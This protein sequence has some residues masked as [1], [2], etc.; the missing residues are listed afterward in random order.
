MPEPVLSAEEIDALLAPA[1][2][3]SGP[4]AI[5]TAPSTRLSFR[6]GAPG[7]VALQALLDHVGESFARDLAQIVRSPLEIEAQRLEEVP[8]R[9]ATPS[10]RWTCRAT[11]P[12]E[13]AKHGS[14]LLAFDSDLLGWLM[15]RML[16][17]REAIQ[18]E[19]G[20]AM[21]PIEERMVL[22]IAGVYY[23]AFARTADCL[24]G[25]ALDRVAA[26][27]AFAGELRTGLR[28]R[29]AVKGTTVLGHAE[30]QF[31]WDAARKLA[32][33]LLTKHPHDNAASE[34]TAEPV[35]PCGT[36]VTA[37]LPT[38]ELPADVRLEAGDVIDTEL[39]ALGPLV[40]AV[41]GTPQF[42]GTPSQW[43]GRL[44]VEI[45]K[46]GKKQLND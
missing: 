40:I 17:G 14:L 1:T 42:Q 44:V 16:G 18:L 2:S 24:K 29:F 21:T 22:R 6:P 34:S 45:E 26:E 8:D 23:E 12:G 46:P 33:E 3:Q 11:L 28:W 41:D 38:I 32:E 19:P 31:A 30:F 37:S 39:P 27:S 43:E 15:G 5:P 13:G 9:P 10:G 35:V 20:R 36:L 25:L 4:Q 7:W